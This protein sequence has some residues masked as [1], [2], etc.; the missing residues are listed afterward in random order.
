MKE[1][2]FTLFWKKLLIMNL[3]LIIILV[4]IFGM[5]VG[6]ITKQSTTDSIFPQQTENGYPF[7]DS[8]NCD[9]KSLA[10][11]IDK[12]TSEKTGQY[13][14]SHNQIIFNSFINSLQSKQCSFYDKLNICHDNKKCF[15]ELDEVKLNMRG[16]DNNNNILF[17]YHD[18]NNEGKLKISNLM[19]IFQ[20]KNEFM[21]YKNNLYFEIE[22]FYKLISGYSSFLNI[23]LYE[24]NKKNYD[25]L[26]EITNYEEKV[27]NLFYLHS[28]FLKAQSVLYNNKVSSELD[29]IKYINHCLFESED[30]FTNNNSLFYTSENE[31]E[32]IIKIFE[33]DLI[34]VINCVPEFNNRYSFLVDLN[35]IKTMLKILLFR[36]D[37]KISKNDKKMFNFFLK[38]LSR[39][40]KI[41]FIADVEIR[42]KANIYEKY[43]HYFVFIFICIS[44]GGLIFTNRYFI[45]HR[46]YYGQGSKLLEK[47]K[48]DKY[49]F[50]YNNEHH[51]YW[52]KI[53]EM[54]NKKKEEEM[55]KNENTN[56]NNTSNNTSDNTKIEGD[57]NKC[58]KEELEY[59]EKLANE[60]NGDFILSK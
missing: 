15:N 27:N 28:L 43:K 13:N 53:K 42:Q 4:R 22:P 32:K 45:K 40:I 11:I 25:T 38:E 10:P 33:K 14:K 34:N 51:K 19:Q 55:K 41:I 48:R 26:K 3:G 35:A 58:T 8:I 9:I 56:N 20:T 37:A 6:Y 44:L 30:K 21:N 29:S 50:M 5:I 1:K 60:N 46:D 39:S 57:I 2:R 36:D 12:I 18:T 31:K 16:T 23:K 54:E 52:A 59:I 47:Y 24:Q 49:N 17:N 7:F